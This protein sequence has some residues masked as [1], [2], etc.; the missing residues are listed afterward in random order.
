MLASTFRRTLAPRAAS[1]AC[2][3][4]LLA[5]CPAPG[6]QTEPGTVFL[7][8]PEARFLAT[9]VQ[10]EIPS[11]PTVDYPLVCGG[12]YCCGPDYPYACPSEERCYSQEPD[13]PD[14]AACSRQSMLVSGV[15]VANLTLAPG[16][17]ASA[18]V[19]FARYEPGAVT[20]LLL[21]PVGAAGHFEVPVTDHDSGRASFT[22]LLSVT[23][24]ALEVCQ[25]DCS[26]AGTCEPCFAEGRLTSW[27]LRPA[28][29]DDQ[30]RVVGSRLHSLSVSLGQKHPE[31][32]SDGSECCQPCSVQGGPEGCQITGITVPVDCDCPPN[33]T[34]VGQDLHSDVKQ[35][36]CNGC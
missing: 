35:C 34:F 32:C 5:A 12:E 7:V 28:L 24:P 2:A 6:G 27:L 19:S 17:A 23:R 1:A 33:T 18:W 10:P 15:S 20:A 14:V 36:L 11:C 29:R 16:Q 26:R 22:I 21:S 9:E 31:G 4:W 13:C 25:Q 3:L 30:D 8:I